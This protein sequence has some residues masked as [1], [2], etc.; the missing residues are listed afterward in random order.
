VIQAHQFYST[1]DS[2]TAALGGP[3]VTV[4]NVTA[5]STLCYLCWQLNKYCHLN[6]KVAA[7]ISDAFRR[8]NVQWTKLN[9]A[10]ILLFF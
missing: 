9:F 8:V 4:S 2:V 7:A 1:S 3:I 10:L 6:C 5:P